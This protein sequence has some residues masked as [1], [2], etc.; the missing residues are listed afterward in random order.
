MMPSITASGT[1]Q[2]LDVTLD[3]APVPAAERGPD[4]RVVDGRTVLALDGS[5]L[6][7]LLTGPAVRL[8]TLGLTAG[9]ADS[10]G[11]QLFTLTYGG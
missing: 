4:L 1:G 6:F 10:A 7:H 11:A 3:G 9:S 2:V 5:R 8:G